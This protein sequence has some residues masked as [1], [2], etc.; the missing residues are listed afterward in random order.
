MAGLQYSYSLLKPRGNAARWVDCVFSQGILTMKTGHFFGC[1]S[2]WLES[3]EK[4]DSNKTLQ[5]F[6]VSRPG[7]LKYQSKKIP[8]ISFIWIVVLTQT[9]L[10]HFSDIQHAVWLWCQSHKHKF[11]LH[12]STQHT[13]RSITSLS[14]SLLTCSC[15]IKHILQSTSTQPD[16]EHN[17]YMAIYSILHTLGYFTSPTKSVFFPNLFSHFYMCS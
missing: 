11:S 15:C 5:C 7:L 2:F 10:E 17:E 8:I 3:V 1:R 13:H 12:L 14:C 6:L 9:C 4:N 16:Y